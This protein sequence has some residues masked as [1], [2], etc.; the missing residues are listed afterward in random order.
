MKWI[1]FWEQKFQIHFGGI[2]EQDRVEWSG[3]DR[4]VTWFKFERM[5][6]KWNFIKNDQNQARL[7]Q[8]LLHLKFVLPISKAR[9]TWGWGLCLG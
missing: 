3:E 4:I 5:Y 7:T 2:A 9:L 6:L 8:N 1:F